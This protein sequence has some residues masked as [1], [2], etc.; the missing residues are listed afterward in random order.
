[1]D[2]RWV[3]VEIYDVDSYSLY[4]WV[5][6]VV[7]V[8]IGSTES[9]D[10]ITNDFVS[11]CPDF[12]ST[13]G[14]VD[15][16]ADA[17]YERSL[18]NFIGGGL[19]TGYVSIFPSSSE[20]LDGYQ[21]WYH[22]GTGRNPNYLSFLFEAKFTGSQPFSSKNAY[23]QAVNHINLLASERDR[24]FD[25]HPGLSFVGTPI[26]VVASQNKYGDDWDWPDGEVRPE[27]RL[28]SR[29]EDPFNE[30]VEID[31]HDELVRLANSLDV[32]IIHAKVARVDLPSPL[33]DQWTR[34]LQFQFSN[35]VQWADHTSNPFLSWLAER[36]ATV[37]PSQT[38][39]T[40]TYPAD[41]DLQCEAA[42]EDQD[43]PPPGGIQL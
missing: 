41:L 43:R 37:D 13:W 40:Y 42:Q 29:G 10:S 19:G 3:G 5:D 34:N 39:R 16:E 4:G 31:Y 8:P 26:Y 18:A 12:G 33:P 11:E 22:D 38:G 21:S 20:G 2:E 28:G 24:F 30:G 35:E 1:M 14:T 27:W 9:K 7:V 17:A 32:A 36:L 23:K 15:R 25:A 6:L